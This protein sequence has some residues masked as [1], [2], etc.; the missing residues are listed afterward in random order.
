MNKKIS[1]QPSIKNNT[2]TGLSPRIQAPTGLNHIASRRT[3]EQLTETMG[4]IPAR[5]NLEQLTSLSSL[6][7]TYLPAHRHEEFSDSIQALLDSGALPSSRSKRGLRLTKARVRKI[8]AYMSL[9]HTSLSDTKGFRLRNAYRMIYYMAWTTG[10][11][12]D[13][14][15]LGTLLQ[16]R[17]RPC[18]SSTPFE[19][20]EK[21]FM[22]G[23]QAIQKIFSKINSLDATYTL[24][25]GITTPPGMTYLPPPPPDSAWPKGTTSTLPYLRQSEPPPSYDPEGDELYGLW[26][27]A[28]AHLAE[29]LN[30]AEGSETEPELG[31][32]GTMG[33]FSAGTA[34]FLW[35]TRDELL[36]Y[37]MEL[38]MHIFDQL[39]QGSRRGVEEKIREELGYSR[40]EA[41]MLCKTALRYGDWL[42]GDDV[43]SSKT[44]ELISLEEISDIA[45]KGNDP[46]AQIAARK[47]IALL[48]G[49]VRTDKSSEQEEFRDLASR[50][51]SGDEEEDRLLE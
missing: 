49:F 2:P 29:M 4:T 16:D 9:D 25:P 41:L 19:A 44:R 26:L 6:S 7:G 18:P 24:K 28:Y 8:A 3:I 31:V 32:Y 10:E 42:Y 39:T 20:P 37:E 33:L 14:S 40:P 13:P 47:H 30:I 23:T 22:Y 12:S 34:R 1:I 43:A 38:M 5:R 35:P 50:A 46:R 36:M 48:A 45:K 11:I 15:P 21:S 51:L 17:Y 27:D